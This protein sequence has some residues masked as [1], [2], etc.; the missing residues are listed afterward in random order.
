[1]LPGL[2]GSQMKVFACVKN[3]NTLKHSITSHD[4]RNL[5]EPI[6]HQDETKLATGYKL[7]EAN[8]ES[9]VLTRPLPP[10]F[11][12]NCAWQIKISCPTSKEGAT[13]RMAICVESVACL[14]FGTELKLRVSG[15]DAL[16]ASGLES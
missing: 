4:R 6:L 12:S 5:L 14:M 15:G 8:S 1:M 11:L 2:L 9:A 7:I 16:Q 10:L 3:G 13:N